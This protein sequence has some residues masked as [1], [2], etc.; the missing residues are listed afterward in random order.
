MDD[1][2]P[3]QLLPGNCPARGSNCPLLDKM[4]NCYYDKCI[5]LAESLKLQ[6]HYAELLNQHDGGKRKLF[7]T[8]DSWEA[9]LRKTGALPKRQ[10]NP[11]G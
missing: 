1:K 8:V 2:K 5:A 11:N 9:R 6:E 10:E 7:K 3:T 4:M